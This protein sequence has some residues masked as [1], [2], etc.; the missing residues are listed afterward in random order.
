M[1]QELELLEQDE[2]EATALL[3][4]A[5]QKKRELIEQQQLALQAAEAEAHQAYLE[6]LRPIR[7]LQVLGVTHAKLRA[8]SVPAIT[9]I[10]VHSDVLKLLKAAVVHRSEP[11]FY[12]LVSALCVRLMQGRKELRSVVEQLSNDAATK[13]YFSASSDDATILIV[14]MGDTPSGMLSDL[15]TTYALSWGEATKYES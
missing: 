4:E 3:R 8:V 12:Q 10:H 5:Q 1:D 11:E 7:E 9:V 14:G 6:R 13:H 2:R 15:V